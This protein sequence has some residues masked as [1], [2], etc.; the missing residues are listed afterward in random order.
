MS[1]D[2]GMEIPPGD[3]PLFDQEGGALDEAEEGGQPEGPGGFAGPIGKK[4]ER[5]SVSPPEG[6]EPLRRVAAHADDLDAPGSQLL[7][8]VAEV[9]GLLRAIGGMGTRIEVEEDLAGGEEV[10][11]GD[12]PS[13][14]IAEGGRRR[15]GTDQ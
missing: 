7:P 9:A 10:S 2:A 5:Q 1:F 8:V 11:Q 14:G 12:A 6:G 4:E 13:L 15:S 3:D